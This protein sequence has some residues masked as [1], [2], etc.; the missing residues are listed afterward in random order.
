MSLPVVLTPEAQTEFDEAVDWYEQQ[1]GLGADFV[2]RIREV[3]QRIGSMPRMHGVIYQDVRRGV[4]RRYSYSVLYRE[5][6]DRVEVIAVFHSSRDPS[7]W[8]KRV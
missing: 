7:E 4:V 2:A 1:A 8:Q 5:R 6:P 3:L